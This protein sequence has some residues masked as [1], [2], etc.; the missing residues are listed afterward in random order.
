MASRSFSR[1]Q[2]EL[3]GSTCGFLY[4]LDGG[5]IKGEVATSQRVDMHPAKHLASITHEP[6]TIEVGLSPEGEPLFDWVSATLDKGHVRKDGAFLR[7]DFDFNVQTRVEFFDAV[8]TEVGLPAMDGS[9]K[10]PC[11]LTL[12]GQPVLYRYRPVDG[13][14][15]TAGSDVSA[16][17]WLASNFRLELGDLP[18]EKVSKVDAL[19]WKQGTTKDEVGVFREPTI[20]PTKVEVSNITLTISTADLEPWMEW[21][22]SFVIDGKCTDADELSGSLTYLAPDLTDEFGRVAFFN[23]GIISLRQ[24]PAEMNKDT[25][26]RFTVELYCEKMAIEIG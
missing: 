16:K 18:C 14:K 20:L 9:S 15:L 11:K 1:A 25:I 4:S 12:K 22:K 26:S 3:D 19:T 10:D 6:F 2:L 24:E 5:T 8:L 23:V 21:H 13:S 7:A 17:Q